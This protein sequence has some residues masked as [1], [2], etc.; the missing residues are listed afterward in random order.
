MKRTLVVAF[1]LLFTLALTWPLAAQQDGPALTV[2]DDLT[3]ED[4][5]QAQFRD[6]NF[7]DFLRTLGLVV[8][9]TPFN[10]ADGLGDGP[11]NPNELPV[12]EPRGSLPALPKLGLQMQF[13]APQ[14]GIGQRQAGFHVAA[15]TRRTAGGAAMQQGFIHLRE[16]EVFILDEADR[17]LDMGFR[18]QIEDIERL[19]EEVRRRVYNIYGEAVYVVETEPAS[20]EAAG[21]DYRL[22][23][24]QIDVLYRRDGIAGV[25]SGLEAGDLVVTSG[26]LKLYPSLRVSIVDDVADYRSTLQ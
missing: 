2:G 17:M 1:A 23:A 25:R 5:A 26:Q 15:D 11:F 22:A 19:G 14:Q 12:T 8:F 7:L 16:V 3:Q 20:D 13:S 10:V 21:P 18:P 6:S 4:I 9:T 24:R